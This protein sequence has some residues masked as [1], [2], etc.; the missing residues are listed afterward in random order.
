MNLWLVTALAMPGFA[1]EI[2]RLAAEGTYAPHAPVEADDFP[3]VEHIPHP[4]STP[5]PKPLRRSNNINQTLY[6]KYVKAT[7]AM[8]GL[9]ELT[10]L[11]FDEEAPT[12]DDVQAG[13][14]CLA[15]TYACTLLAEGRN[16]CT[17]SVVRP[18]VC[19]DYR[20][21]VLRFLA[22]PLLTCAGELET[23]LD[24]APENQPV[25]TGECRVSTVFLLYCV[26]LLVAAVYGVAAVARYTRTL[27][28]NRRLKRL[29]SS[30]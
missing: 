16:Q 25:I 21:G 4:P 8:M 1:D 5:K 29:A 26:G 28:R 18:C 3:T 22:P 27:L 7:R 13:R 12:C 2:T 24:A 15:V 14:G 19:P 11:K 20:K 30:E 23:V 10:D 6:R 9:S 17:P